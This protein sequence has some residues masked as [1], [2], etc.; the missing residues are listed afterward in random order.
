MVTHKIHVYLSDREMRNVHS[1]RTETEATNL[2]N[3][4]FKWMQ[5]V[6]GHLGKLEFFL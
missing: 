2:I 5:L 6:S 4:T 1:M 3:G